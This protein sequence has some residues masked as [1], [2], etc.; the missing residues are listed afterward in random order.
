MGLPLTSPYRVDAPAFI[1]VSGGR[2]SMY[3]LR[4]ILAEYD[5]A[6]PA[7]VHI[8]FCNTGTE[9]EETLVFVNECQTRWSAKIH[10]LE[11]RDNEAGFAEVDFVTA[12]RAGAPF[13]TLI[14]RKGYVPNRGAP[15]CSI[16]LKQRVARDFM[17]AC[18]YKRWNSYVGLRH[19]E[20]HRI[21]GA[22]GRNASKKDPWNSL[23]PLDRAKV[24][25][26][27]VGDHWRAQPFDLGLLSYQDNCR[28]CWKKSDAKRRRIIRDEQEAGID[29][30]WWREQEALTGTTF[31]LKFSHA[32]LEQEVRDEPMMQ[33]EDWDDTGDSEECGF[34]CVVADADLL[35][36][37]AAA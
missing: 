13:A 1:S 12:D 21:D 26:R 24:S 33:I 27:D 25:K 28:R 20:Q 11:Y 4:Q 23:F 5:G 34:E 15:Y 2:S 8:G 9:R 22:A 31:D 37:K 30:S 3:M 18:G 19:D 16:E 32:R 35:D 7:D 14:A 29:D 10:W 36:L 6:L 17:Q